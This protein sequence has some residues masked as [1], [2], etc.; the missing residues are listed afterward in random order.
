MLGALYRAVAVRE[1]G[2]ED[3]LISLSTVM[4]G[5]REK[6]GPVVDVW[7]ETWG[8]VG[9]APVA[10][11]GGPGLRP[12]FRHL[13]ATPFRASSFTSRAFSSGEDQRKL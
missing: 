9:G 4:S 2:Q 6:P 12:Q 5:G 7:G 13:L 1:G 3:T 8:V 10:E 11:L